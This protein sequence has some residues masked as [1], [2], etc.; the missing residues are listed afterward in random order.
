MCP[1]ARNRVRQATQCTRHV[2][3]LKRVV[4]TCA[5]NPRSACPSL[6]TRTPSTDWFE[7]SQIIWDD[8]KSTNNRS[9]SFLAASQRYYITLC[10]AIT[11]SKATL[12]CNR[13]TLFESIEVRRLK[14]Q[15]RGRKPFDAAHHLFGVSFVRF[16]I[17]WLWSANSLQ[18][19]FLVFAWSQPWRGPPFWAGACTRC[20]TETVVTQDASAPGKPAAVGMIWRKR[21]RDFRK[22]MVPRE[23]LQP[24]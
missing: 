15:Q 21:A 10:Q 18:S 11:V 9:A 23:S 16:R 20:C 2:A 3:E 22:S 19:R 4:T 12:I 1:T 6:R 17:D 13:V 5:R 8:S 24:N 7:S 14:F